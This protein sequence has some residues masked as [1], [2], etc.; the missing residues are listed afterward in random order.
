MTKTSGRCC[1]NAGSATPGCG[2]WR[3]LSSSLRRLSKVPKAGPAVSAAHSKDGNANQASS[4]SAVERRAACVTRRP[5]VRANVPR[6]AQDQHRRVGGAAECGAHLAL[7]GEGVGAVREALHRRQH[8]AVRG[9][10]IADL[11]G[12]SRSGHRDRQRQRRVDR[13]RPEGAADLGARAADAAGLHGARRYQDRGRPEGQAAV[14]DRRRRRLLQL[15]DGPRGAEIGASRCRATP[16]SSPPR[17]RAGCR[18]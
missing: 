2:S 13:P 4:G 10:P 1:N 12:G 8:R 11:G 17:P 5:G 3:A 14:G 6:P 7:R 16:S 18:A 15:A 9:R